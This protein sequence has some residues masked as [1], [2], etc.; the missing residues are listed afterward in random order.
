MWLRELPENI[1]TEAL[2]GDFLKTGE[3]TDRQTR[4][5][6][7]GKLVSFLPLVNYTLLRSLCAHLIRVIEHSEKNKM[8]LRNISI[9]FSATLGIPSSIFNLLLVDFDYI[10]WTN[11]CNENQAVPTTETAIQCYM[12]EINDEEVEHITDSYQLSVPPNEENTRSKRN[13][14]LYQT[15]TPKDFIL[16]EQQLHGM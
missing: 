5:S 12:Q 16:L 1:C 7:V 8:T 14:I 10:F 3:L 6:E 11:R 2:L 9:V 13:S 15:S 4:V